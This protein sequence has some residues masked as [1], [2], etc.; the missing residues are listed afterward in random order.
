MRIALFVSCTLP[1]AKLAYDAFFNL[2]GDNP[3][4]A[5]I[6]ETGDWAMFFLMATL[7]IT[8]LRRLPGANRL[9]SYRRMLGLFSFFYAA[10]HCITYF[11]LDQH[12]LGDDLATRPFV[13]PGMAAS[14]LMVPLAFTSTNGWIRRLGK[15]WRV[16]HRWVYVIAVSAALHYLWMRKTEAKPYLYA[17]IFAMLLGWRLGNHLITNRRTRS[18]SLIW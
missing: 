8:P 4:E 14:L 17:T 12:V 18:P 10:L 13:L 1:A 5:L 3:V 16:L 7:A 9:I 2:L 11:W 6:Y 15:K